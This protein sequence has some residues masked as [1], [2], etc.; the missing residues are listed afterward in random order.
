AVILRGNMI[1]AAGCY[2]PL[3]ENPFISKELGTR[4]RAAIGMTEVSDAICV[5]VSEET[6]KIS[7]AIN[8]QLVRDIE[9]ESLITKL[10]DDLQARTKSKVRERTSFWKR[11]G[12][13]NG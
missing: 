6:G 5:I 4:H 7:L 11:K 3:S 9:E 1:M 10:Y 12:E 2:L 8:G 13:P